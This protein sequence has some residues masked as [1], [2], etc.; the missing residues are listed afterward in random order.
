MVI[1]KSKKCGMLKNKLNLTGIAGNVAV[2]SSCMLSMLS[3]CQNL[4]RWT[5]DVNQFVFDVQFHLMCRGASY[6]NANLQR[7]SC[8][9]SFCVS[10][11]PPWQYKPFH[12][13][14]TW[15]SMDAS[16][17]QGTARWWITLWQ[18]HVQSNLYLT[19]LSKV[20]WF[21]TF[22]AFPHGALLHL[23]PALVLFD[24]PNLKQKTESRV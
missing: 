11:S 3:R 22:L 1:R 19:S 13:L 8:D 17:S 24:L 2:R 5:F 9:V 4:Q 20:D 6:D 18:I 16:Q 15:D 12:T 21:S 10:K 14:H 23:P 7:C